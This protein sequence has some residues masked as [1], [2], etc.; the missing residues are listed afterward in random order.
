MG[1]Q[2]SK[3]DPFILRIVLWTLLAPFKLLTWL[4]T[5]SKY[6]KKKKKNDYVKIA[7]TNIFK[8]RFIAKKLLKRELYPNEV[9]HH[10]NGDKADNRLINLCVLDKD[11]HEEFHSWLSWQKR[12][13]GDYPP[14]QKQKKRLESDYFSGILL[15]KIPNVAMPSKEEPINSDPKV[16]TGQVFIARR[17]KTTQKLFLEFEDEVLIGPDG[18]CVEVDEVR[19]ESSI[20]VKI[21]QITAKQLQVYQRKLNQRDHEFEKVIDKNHIKKQLFKELKKER[22]KLAKENKVPAYII[23]HDSTLTEIAEVMPVSK[24][25]LLQINGVGPDKLEKYGDQ[26]LNIVKNFKASN[27]ES[28]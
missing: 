21:K 24:S 25:L 16:E 2:K 13:K 23:F 26:F 22:L 1:R 9:V 7:G 15:E 17:N 18:H 14:F 20:E 11:K 5:G 12:K 4:F 19:F 3:L 8:H 6:L 10:I 28:A 27:S